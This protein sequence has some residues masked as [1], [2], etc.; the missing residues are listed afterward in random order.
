MEGVFG[1]GAVLSQ[2]VPEVPGAV[3]DVKG[4]GSFA[5]P[6]AQDGAGGSGSAG[7]CSGTAP[8]LPKERNPCQKG[9]V[10]ADRST[11]HSPC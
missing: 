7:L 8:A 11:E 3:A 1:E 4:T 6:Q 10:S 9:F 5:H 2:E